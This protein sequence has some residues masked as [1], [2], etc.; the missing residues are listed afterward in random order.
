MPISSVPWMLARSVLDR[1]ADAASRL[2]LT[3]VARAGSLTGRA[4]HVLLRREPH[5]DELRQLFS[6]VDASIAARADALA[7]EMSALRYRNRVVM[8]I[9]ARRGI[10][11]LAPIVS[12]QA[13]AALERWRHPGRPAILIGWHLG[14]V[15]GV[16][17]TVTRSRLPMLVVHRDA[18]YDPDRSLDLVVTGTSMAMRRQVARRAT[19]HL[20]AGGVVA[21]AV[22]VPDVS[23]TA[24]VRCLGRTVQFARGPFALARMTGADIAPIV[25]RWSAD[26][27]ILL[28]VG[29]PLFADGDDE[30]AFESR[31]AARAAGWL[32]QYVLARPAQLWVILLRWLLSGRRLA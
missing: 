32:E 20:D 10:A 2:D 17:A 8:G 9:V 13:Q 16:A 27:R 26:H 14:A 30:D 19:R 3:S 11:S 25:P 31:A 15:C 23:L 5:P 4:A 6:S 7:A 18:L 24:G 22:D 21:L 12:E 29:A 28:D 1:A